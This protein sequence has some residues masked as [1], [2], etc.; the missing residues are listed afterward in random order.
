M[1]D[2]SLTLDLIQRQASLLDRLAEDMKRYALKRDGIRSASLSDE[3]AAA[4][5]RGL[6][7]VARARCITDRVG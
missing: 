5:K 2:T 7:L 4:S 6:S 1:K 3:E